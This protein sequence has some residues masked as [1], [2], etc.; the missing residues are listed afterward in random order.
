[1]KI[2][3]PQLVYDKVMHWVDKTSIEVSGFGTVRYD[4]NTKTFHVVDAYLLKQEGGAAHT[5]IDNAALADL[6]YE[7]RRSGL[8]LKW[9]WHSHVKMGVFWSGTDTST[10]KEMGQ[11]GW[12]V[13]TVFNQQRQMKSAAC[14]KTTTDFGELINLSD[15]IPTVISRPDVTPEMFAAWDKE[16]DDNV[17]EK[18]YSPP[19]YLGYSSYQSSTKD[20]QEAQAFGQGA[21]DNWDEDDYYTRW[22]ER[23]AKETK[24]EQLAWDPGILGYGV[25]KEAAVLGL[26]PESYAAILDQPGSY[27]I[28]RGYTDRLQAAELDG[29][30]Q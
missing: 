12:I 24:E 25:H 30:L 5:D 20:S 22:Q 13:A 6:V 14:Y 3:I 17:K 15:D 11:H 4:A 18:K 9:W 8:E 1:M 23:A 2:D 27:G 19:S 26:T 7:T 10:I 28:R 21:M 29:R 16:F